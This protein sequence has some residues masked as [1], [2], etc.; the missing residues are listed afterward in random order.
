V[1]EKYEGDYIAKYGKTRSLEELAAIGAIWGHIP[2]LVRKPDRTLWGLCLN[3]LAAMDE[4]REALRI[5]IQ[6]DNT[7]LIRLENYLTTSVGQPPDSVKTPLRLK[8]QR[9]P[10]NMEDVHPKV[11]LAALQADLAALGRDA[12][13]QKGVSANPRVMVFIDDLHFC[14]AA[15]QVLTEWVT[16]NGLGRGADQIVPFVFTYSSVDQEVYR[17]V[18]AAIRNEAESRTT[19]IANVDLKSL[20]PPDDDELPYRQFLLSQKPMLVPTNES[21]KRDDFFKKLHEKVK[22]LPSRLETRRENDDVQSWVDS[23][24]FF[25]LLM[26]ADDDKLAAQAGNV[27]NP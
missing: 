23:G 22:G 9:P 2:C 25:E 6:L 15:G 5:P 11:L 17:Q 1:S 10:M 24:V 8:A 4:A 20:L 18:A 12:A 13:N 16:V 26:E 7:D 3:I 21:T 14:P 19:Q 27:G